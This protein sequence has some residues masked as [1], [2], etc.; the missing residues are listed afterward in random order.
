MTIGV[1]KEI[2]A[3]ENRVAMRPAGVE[4]LCRDGHEVQ[5]ESGAGNG[6]G[7]SDE[8]YARVGA[9]IINDAAAI[10]D[11]SEMIVKVKEPL[12]QEFPLMGRGQIIFTYFH[13]AADRELTEA[14]RDSGAIAIAY[15]TVQEADRSLPLLIPMSEVAGRMAVQEGA[16]YLERTFGGRG[17]LLSGVPGTPRA[18]VVV[19][20][21]GIV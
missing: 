14:V 21:G 16:K 3:F 18:E 11:S 19:L 9:K 7:F 12:K 15:E 1:P 17:V 10:W 13:F 4:L 20:G 2:K 5:V 8:E 6:S